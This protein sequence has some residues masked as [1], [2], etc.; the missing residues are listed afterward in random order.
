MGAVPQ[1]LSLEPTGEVGSP[2]QD[3]SNFKPANFENSSHSNNFH[4]EECCQFLSENDF[5]KK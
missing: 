4:F 2:F 5:W 1:G 3:M